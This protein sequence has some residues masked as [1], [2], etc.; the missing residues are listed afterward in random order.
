MIH[1][2]KKNYL[3]SSN[4]VIWNS[5]YVKAQTIRKNMQKAWYICICTHIWRKL[6]ILEHSSLSKMYREESTT[7]IF[8]I[9]VEHYLG[10]QPKG[11]LKGGE[12]LTQCPHRHWRLMVLMLFLTQIS[13]WNE[14]L[15][16]CQIASYF[17]PSPKSSVRASSS[18]IRKQW[19]QFPALG[20]WD[21]QGSWVTERCAILP[22]EFPSPATAKHSR[23]LTLIW[24][25]IIWR[26]VEIK[27]Q[28]ASE[29]LSL[30]N[31]SQ[32]P[33]LFSDCQSLVDRISSDDLSRGH[34]G[35][36][37]RNRRRKPWR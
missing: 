5:L 19:A 25:T 37:R 8:W 36:A 31:C 27:G 35:P 9:G 15:F 33:S 4:I 1:Y 22:W 3:F 2:Q 28:I 6:W 26:F 29:C 21:T 7:S 30:Q 23:M 10:K 17:F 16:L 20:P 32:V 14:C 12:G 18:N 11:K 13:S 34:P 24:N